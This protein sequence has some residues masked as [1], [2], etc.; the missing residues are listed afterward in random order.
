MEELKPGLSAEVSEHVTEQLT[1]V[2]VRSGLVTSYATPSMIALMENASVVALQ[3]C[4]AR[5]Q[6]SVGT[7]INVKHIAATPVFGAWLFLSHQARRR[8]VVFE[9]VDV[10]VHHENRQGHGIEQDA[11]KS[12][13]Q[14]LNIKPAHNTGTLAGAT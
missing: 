2:S 5:G 1:A 9:D 6:T 14:K 13:I 3:K 12:L 7:E 4:L 8:L 11:V 10:L